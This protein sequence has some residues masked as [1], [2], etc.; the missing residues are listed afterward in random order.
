MN[1][2]FSKKRKNFLFK[3]LKKEEKKMADERNLIIKGDLDV[4]FGISSLR[5]GKVTNFKGNWVI[6]TYQ[7]GDIVEDLLG[8][9]CYLSKINNNNDP[10]SVS[11]S[12]C[13]LTLNI[14]DFP[15]ILNTPDTDPSNYLVPLCEEPNSRGVLMPLSDF[16]SL[17]KKA[18]K[19]KAFLQ[20]GPTSEFLNILSLYPTAS[21]V[22]FILVG[23]GGGGG[24]GAGSTGT[25]SDVDGTGGGNQTY[26]GQ[27][28][29]G[30]QAGD[31]IYGSFTSP[32]I[33]GLTLLTIQ[34]GGN[35]GGFGSRGMD[36]DSLSSPPPTDGNY[37]TA[38]TFGYDGGDTKFGIFTAVGGGGGKSYQ[39]LVP[40][41][42]VAV[43]N[44]SGGSLI[45][46]NQ[47]PGD[48]SS[49]YMIFENVNAS[50]SGGLSTTNGT[51]YGKGG[52]GGSTNPSSSSSGEKGGD[53]AAFF[54][55]YY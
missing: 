21:Y 40:F 52:A 35:E 20:Y 25:Y 43:P 33:P 7:I 45:G 15:I 50:F 49:G 1:S 27:A 51:I 22:E 29:S 17:L 11:A 5:G 47:P 41:G 48:S 10:L 42:P 9:G 12:W 4:P 46:N 28:G 53:G 2:F 44:L 38:A 26:V 55:I 36:S 6:G 32:S 37:P 23:G 16:N 31:V 3:R 8:S 14:C 54:Y 18:G 24:G 13:H 19:T 39:S 30:G 34:G